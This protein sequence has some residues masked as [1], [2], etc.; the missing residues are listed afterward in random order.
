MDDPDSSDLTMWS[1]VN[2]FFFQTLEKDKMPGSRRHCSLVACLILGPVSEC[3]PGGSGKVVW[4]RKQM[5]FPKFL[6]MQTMQNPEV[7]DDCNTPKN[8]NRK[9]T[10]LIG[11]FSPYEET[12]AKGSLQFT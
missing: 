8:R 9:L 4:R 11:H 1:G 12:A 7:A 5:S 2:I 3:L 6:T 10:H